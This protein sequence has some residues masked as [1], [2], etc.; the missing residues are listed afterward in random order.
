M[1]LKVLHILGVKQC[2]DGNKMGSIYLGVVFVSFFLTVLLFAVLKRTK[3]NNFALILIYS[4]LI[5]GY[6][7]KVKKNI[8]EYDSYNE[9][10]YSEVIKITVNNKVIKGDKS[11]LL[12]D[13]LK[14]DSF[15]WVNHPMKKKEYSVSVYTKGRIYSFKILDTYNQ[16]VLVSRVDL[17]GK[18]YVTNR[19][20]NILFFL[21]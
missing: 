21:E 1:F 9:I 7:F 3:I 4:G 20:D 18:D 5:V 11:K 17:K 19:N 10:K 2:G 6:L 12:F 8:D 13:V 15:S 16:G 14:D